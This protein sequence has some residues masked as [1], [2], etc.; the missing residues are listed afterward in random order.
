MVWKYARRWY[1]VGRLELEDLMQVG[2]I[3]V[4]VAHS[5]LPP[6]FAVG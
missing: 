1:G 4:I 3:A 6:A 5:V 2:F